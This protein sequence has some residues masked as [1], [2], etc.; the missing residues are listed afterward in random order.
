MKTLAEIYLPSEHLLINQLF[1]QIQDLIREMKKIPFLDADNN[2]KEESLEYFVIT[3]AN[4]SFNKGGSNKTKGKVTLKELKDTVK[5]A[6]RSD[7]ELTMTGFSKIFGKSKTTGMPLYL[8]I[9]LV[10]D[11]IKKRRIVGQEISHQSFGK[12]IISKIEY[13]SDSIWFKYGDGVKILSMDYFTLNDEDEQKIK[14]K[15]TGMVN[16]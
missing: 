14:N 13:Q 15:I 1:M 10:A 8:L 6:F 7:E 16:E 9:N 4:I 2:P 5:L 11:E 12:G 3:D